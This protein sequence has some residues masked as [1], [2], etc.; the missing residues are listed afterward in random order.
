MGLLSVGKQARKCGEETRA[1]SRHSGPPTLP[2]PLKKVFLRIWVI[3]KDHLWPNSP[4]P[5]LLT[6]LSIEQSGTSEMCVTHPEA[7]TKPPL[8]DSFPYG[9]NRIV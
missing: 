5:L 3:I 6:G 9:S 7:H 1:C 2:Y 8:F 4:P